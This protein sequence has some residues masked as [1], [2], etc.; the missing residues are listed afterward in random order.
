[1]VYDRTSYENW[2]GVID[3]PTHTT[4]ELY[5]PGTAADS[6]DPD[7]FQFP[8]RDGEWQSK[9]P[10]LNR[11]RKSRYK[12]RGAKD[13]KE[14]SVAVP[15]GGGGTSEP[16]DKHEAESDKPE[17]DLFDAALQKVANKLKAMNEGRIDSSDSTD[18]PENE[19]EKAPPDV[20][21]RRGEYVVRKH[22]A[23]R[24]FLFS[25]TIDW[26][27]ASIHAS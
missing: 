14:D 5:V 21:V 12:K 3:L 17:S 6:K 10:E 22:L 19:A 7:E 27:V 11:Y 9:A 26:N 24:N 20:W 25:R 13:G 18:S 4:K 1:M 15:A 8:V 2:K 16:K 23:P